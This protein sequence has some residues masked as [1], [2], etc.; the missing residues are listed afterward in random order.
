MTAEGKPVACR[1]VDC[2][3]VY[4]VLTDNVASFTKSGDTAGSTITITGTDFPTTIKHVFYGASPCG[5]VNVVST[6]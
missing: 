3:F 2:D 4:E 6:T 5:S 1:E